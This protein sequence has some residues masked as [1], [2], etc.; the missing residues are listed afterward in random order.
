[1]RLQIYHSAFTNI[2]Q[3]INSTTDGNLLSISLPSLL[4][5]NETNQQ[6]YT[7]AY[8][9]MN[10]S[11]A[12]SFIIKAVE[13]ML[14]ENGVHRVSQECI[15]T[16]STLM[17]LSIQNI[18]LY[19]RTAVLHFPVCSPASSIHQLPSS[20]DSSSSNQT[21]PTEIRVRDAF[22]HHFHL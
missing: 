1:M 19:L 17:K 21:V 15:S 20:A 8:N 2:E 6:L 13:E 7:C 18:G 12:D 5:E 11:Y 10:E 22:L 9:E 3:N 14:F 4:I 16:L